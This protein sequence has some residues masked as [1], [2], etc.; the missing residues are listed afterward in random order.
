MCRILEYWQQEQQTATD[1]AALG[2]AQT[3]A[4]SSCASAANAEA[5]AVADAQTNGFLNAGNNTVTPVSPPSSGP[6]SGNG[7]AIT[8]SITSQHVSTFFSRLFGYAAGMSETTTATATTQA[9]A[10]GA[11]I[12]LLSANSWSSF[13]GATV[14]APG[15]AIDINYTADFNQGTIAAPY[16]GYAGGTPNYGGTKFTEASPMPMLPVADPV[17]R[18][19]A[20]RTL[21]V[22]HR[23]SP[24]ARATTPMA[25]TTRSI[26]AATRIST[27]IHRERSRCGL[28]STSS[29]ATS[30]TTA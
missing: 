29:T 16:I 18:S 30:T 1:A 12:Y 25:A 28:G 24:T 6:W 7:C 20:A 17:P 19:R 2:G 10:G 11:C 8:V 26:P 9:N 27:S 5:A 15:C 21:P 22:I 14:N 3:L 23:P 13:N 4:R